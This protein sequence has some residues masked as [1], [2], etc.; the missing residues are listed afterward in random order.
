MNSY[1]A[2]NYDAIYGN[3]YVGETCQSLT[4]AVELKLRKHINEWQVNLE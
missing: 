3:Q 2:K 4:A 1:E